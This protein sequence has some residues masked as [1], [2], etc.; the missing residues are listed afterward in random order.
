MQEYIELGPTPSGEDC[1]QLGPNYNPR[2]AAIECSVFVNQLSRVFP[3]NVFG[4]KRFRHDFGTYME[5]VV[6]YDDSV[7]SQ[8]DSAY[9]VESNT[10]EYW[11][12]IARDQL[13]KQLGASL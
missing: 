10:P 6:Y 4:V 2:R 13:A 11:D 9:N 3:D 5:V 7:E 1:E 12:D 8:V